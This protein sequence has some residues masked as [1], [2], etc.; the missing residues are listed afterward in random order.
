MDKQPINILL[1]QIN[2]TV[3]DIE[4]NVKKIIETIELA[5]DKHKADLVIFPEM[6][7]SGYPPE[8]L[9]FRRGFNHKVFEGFEK[10]RHSSKGIAIIVGYPELTTRGC[11]NKAAVIQN[12]KIIAEATK[13]KLPNYSVFDEQRNFI[14]GTKP[15]VFNFM[16]RS[17]SLLICEDLWYSEPAN[18]AKELGAEFIIGIN[19]SPYDSQKPIHRK[20]E[21]IKRINETNLPMFYVN[22]IGGQDELVFDG[23]SMVLDQKG[24]LLSR[25]DFFKENLI[26]A[27][28]KQDN[29]IS[30]GKVS[31]YKD[32][33]HFV[34]QALVLGIKDYVNKNGFPGVLVGNSGGLDSALT[35]TLAVDALGPDRV[36]AVMM[37]SRYSSQTS[38]D[39]ALELVNNLGIKHSVISIEPMFKSF[40]HELADDF[41][42]YQPNTTEENLQARIRGMILMALSNKKGYMVLS[43]GNKS[44]MSVGYATLYGDMAGGFCALK[45]V[46]K[47]LAYDLTTYR[48]NI[49]HKVPH[50]IIDKPPSAELAPDQ[51]DEDS[52]PPYPVLDKILEYYI[53]QDMSTHEIIDLGFDEETV[54]K[55]TR[56][57]SRNEYK[58]RQAPPGV[59]ITTRAFGRDRRYPITS[60]F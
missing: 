36:Q 60:K 10:I 51:K 26:P 4:G 35:L 53:E 43:T 50:N 11:F 19:A 56:M 8:D 57:V 27:T 31:K 30:K 23:G 6:T 47:T 25:G 29:S 21:M 39:D 59:R 24:K 52:L 44:E 17:F 42:G 13:L 15:C 32:I 58:R 41:K 48:N 45:D 28:I 33:K 37:P 38:L 34:Y 14:P 9:V 46:Y 20:D 49:D 54:I 55:I 22:L 12:G 3:G 5:R 2:L 16:G 18:R 40:L 1:A 7:I